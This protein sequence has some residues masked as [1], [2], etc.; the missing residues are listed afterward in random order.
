MTFSQSKTTF[1]SNKKQPVP[2]LNVRG[3]FFDHMAENYT[4]KSV[5][6]FLAVSYTQADP[7]KD[8]EWNG[9]LSTCSSFI[10]AGRS[11]YVHCHYG[12]A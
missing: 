6:L 7:N 9:M 8:E 12:L 5:I 4:Y 1:L 3:T 10:L 2:G 11:S